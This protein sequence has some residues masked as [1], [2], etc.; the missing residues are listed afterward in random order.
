ME[1]VLSFIEHTLVVYK[2]KIKI[3]KS[4]YSYSL[5]E[6]LGFKKYLYWEDRIK[7]EIT[8]EEWLVL[9]TFP[10]VTSLFDLYEAVQVQVAGISSLIDGLL[11][12]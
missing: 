1:Y 3:E 5:E 9:W 6:T 10:E 8:S 11:S 7:L 2:H 4:P 12:E